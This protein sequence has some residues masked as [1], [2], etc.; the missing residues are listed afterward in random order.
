ML[1]RISVWSMEL[2]SLKQILE[3]EVEMYKL[4]QMKKSKM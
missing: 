3:E 4:F 1:I 2:Y